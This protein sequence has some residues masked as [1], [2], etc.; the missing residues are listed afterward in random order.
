MATPA[1]R[2]GQPAARHADLSAVS[3][4]RSGD[5]WVARKV[6]GNGVVCVSW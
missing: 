4:D 3:P 5:D 1:S 2:F 6:G